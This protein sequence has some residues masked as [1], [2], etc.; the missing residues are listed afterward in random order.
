MIKCLDDCKTDKDYEQLFNTVYL[1][2]Y[3]KAIEEFALHE[4]ES[5][6]KIKAELKQ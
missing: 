2:I 1:E 5:C 3:G 6:D 4:A